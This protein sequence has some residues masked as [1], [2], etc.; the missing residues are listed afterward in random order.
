[1]LWISTPVVLSQNGSSGWSAARLSGL[2]LRRGESFLFGFRSVSLLAGRIR[3][4][5]KLAIECEECACHCW[6]EFQTLHFAYPADE[7]GCAL[8]K[9]RMCERPAP[10]DVTRPTLWPGALHA[11]RFWY[12]CGVNF[13]Q[14]H[15]FLQQVSGQSKFKGSRF[16]LTYHA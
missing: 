15:Y 14:T 3:L 16:S 2:G 10:R 4:S 11:A 5:W 6:M 12:L 9:L 1:M 7:Q 8:G 13:P